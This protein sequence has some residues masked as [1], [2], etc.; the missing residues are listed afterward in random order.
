MCFLNFLCCSKNGDNDNDNEETANEETALLDGNGEGNCVP[1]V[2]PVSIAETIM[3]D[4][5]HI[6]PCPLPARTNNSRTDLFSPAKM[7]RSKTAN[8]YDY[9]HLHKD[10]AQRVE[11]SNSK[12]A[13]ADVCKNENMSFNAMERRCTKNNNNNNSNNNNSNSNTNNSNNNNNNDNEDEDEDEDADLDKKPAAKPAA[14]K[15][16]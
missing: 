16:K 10:R 9:Y 6:E 7:T 11:Y 15:R 1:A 14:K 5:E 4:E 8:K 13:F 3:V 2:L 12:L